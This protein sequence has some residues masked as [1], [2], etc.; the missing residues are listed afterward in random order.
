VE[1]EK[2]LRESGLQ[3][4]TWKDTLANIKAKL[5]AADWD[6]FSRLH[7][8][9]V[10]YRSDDTLARFYGFVFSRGLQL[11]INMH[12]FQRL[13][14]ILAD[15]ESEIKPGLSIL[16]IGAGS[17]L[18]ASIVQ[19]RLS[20]SDYVVQDPCG[21][22]RSALDA[23]GFSVLPHP[24]PAAP[25]GKPF[26]L[27]LCA[28]SLGEVNADEDGMLSE[29]GKVAPQDFVFLMEERYGIAQKLHPWRS[30]LAP[31][32][33]VLL[34]EPFV[35]RGAWEALAALLSE[36]GWNPTIQSPSANRT[37]LELKLQ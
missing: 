2:E 6:K 34:W 26:D 9:F 10:G 18:L 7:R 17:G 32:G 13:A 33:R 22:V 12:R 19:R 35:H 14:L 21:E 1:A 29:T 4:G 16:D 24:A 31:G 23:Q 30:Y 27:I 37:F 5:P 8:N 15:L 36:E 20:P 28:D 11:D 3:P 25:A